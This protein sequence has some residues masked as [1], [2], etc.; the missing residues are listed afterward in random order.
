MKGLKNRKLWETVTGLAAVFG[1]YLAFCLS[2][3]ALSH[4]YFLWMLLHL[5]ILCGA[6]VTY[7][8]FCGITAERVN[9]R[10]QM[11]VC[12]GVL[13]VC[14]IL[15]FAADLR[16]GSGAMS[17]GISDGMYA[18]GNAAGGSGHFSADGGKFSICAR[19]SQVLCIAVTTAA[20][21]MLYHRREN[22]GKIDWRTWKRRI[23]SHGLLFG[24]CAVTL[25]LVYDP[26][27]RQFKWDGGLY[28]LACRSASVYSISSMALYGHISQT[29]GALIR[30][31]TVV[32]GNDPAIGMMM[33]NAIMLLLSICAFY[34][35]M[36]ALLPKRRE[37]VYVTAAAVYAWS[38]FALG[39]VNYYSLDF[40]CMCLFPVVLYY[41][42]RRQWILQVLSG[43]CFCF[44]K[45]PAII[46][47]GTLCVGVVAADFWRGKQGGSVGGLSGRVKRLFCTPRY[48]AMVSVALLWIV[49]ICLL[50][51]WSGGSGGFSVDQGYIVE[52][53]KVLYVLNF[54][55][56][57]TAL[58]FA[59]GGILAIRKKIT[60]DKIFLLLPLASAQAGFTLFSS[61][62][63]TVNHARYAGVSPVCLYL[64]CVLVL[65]MLAEEIGTWGKRLLPF[66]YA[67]LAGILLISCYRTIDAVS[68]RVF[69][70]VDIGEETMISTGVAAPGDAMIY[71]KQALWFE[72]AVSRAM[73]DVD[74]ENVRLLFPT[75]NGS[76]YY[77][78]AFATAQ[79]LADGEYREFMEYWNPKYQVR[80]SVA[81]ENSI[82]FC[83]FLIRDEEALECLVQEQPAEKYAYLYTTYAGDEI[84]RRIRAEYHVTAQEQYSYR[85]WIVYEIL[86]EG[87]AE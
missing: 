62:F 37:I 67:A 7:L 5:V 33:G 81:A 47:Y 29:V 35:S 52:K 6:G 56:I 68:L 66:V 82:P 74:L 12:N 76:A 2:T 77:F 85:G 53:W 60:A 87:E 36:K 79:T 54:N 49:T 19:L 8:L 1:V 84:A 55:W 65:A 59:G 9:V 57:C 83:V 58:I 63:V 78:E 40:Y 14:G 4:E 23:A 45:E 18:I 50:G 24:L 86:F 15:F 28:Y 11:R 70:N 44:T 16:N 51:A 41:T 30:F 73:A 10:R 72:A 38:P 43:M 39:M 48:Y 27:M 20:G 3:I 71:N 26:A 25:I 69:C 46:V 32:L 64:L 13:W 31:L 34:G 42:I 61:L 75:V 22:G 17:T 21:W 80:E